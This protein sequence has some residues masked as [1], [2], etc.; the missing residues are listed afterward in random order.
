MARD[1][2]QNQTLGAVTGDYLNATVGPH[3]VRLFRVWRAGSAGVKDGP[4]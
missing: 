3:E 4:P 2:W 1:V